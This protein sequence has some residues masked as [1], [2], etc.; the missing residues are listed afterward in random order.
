MNKT[1]LKYLAGLVALVC[2]TCAFALSYRG[3]NI[4]HLRVAPGSNSANLVN[5]NTADFVDQTGTNSLMVTTNRYFL[6]A[7]NVGPR[8]AVRN[9]TNIYYAV[10]YREIRATN[11]LGVWFTNY[12]RNGLI[13]EN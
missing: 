4:H 8:L 9:G 13:T 3:H 11:N 12:V 6:G 5:T 2:M 10:T 1:K 7:T